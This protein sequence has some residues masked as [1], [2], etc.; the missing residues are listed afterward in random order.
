MRTFILY[1]LICIAFSC[2]CSHLKSQAYLPLL[3]VGKKWSVD[4]FSVAY[5]A[6]TSFCYTEDYF[7]SG[8]TIIDG[9]Q[10]FKVALYQA[11]NIVGFLREDV[12]ERKIYALLDAEGLDYDEEILM[13]DFSLQVGD[14]IYLPYEYTPYPLKLESIETITLLDGAI[15]KKI[16]FTNPL[17]LY[18]G[19][20][21]YIEGIGGA[22][23]LM[24]PLESFF[25]T[26]W[27]LNCVTLNDQSLYGSSSC[28]IILNTKDVIQERVVNIFP[29]PFINE[30]EIISPESISEIS[31]FDVS[32]DILKRHKIH[33]NKK[34]K[35]KINNSSV[36][37]YF[38]HLVFSDGSV[39]HKKIV[40][41]N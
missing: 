35:I 22:R 25:E 39:A 19:D 33:N 30:I 38:L 24:F 12:S 11:Q 32:G 10:Y 16:I 34:A 31:L 37:V 3:E 8:D 18:E 13:Y 15:S 23:G 1:V 21:F 7:L 14:S 9:N 5:C 41:A 27:Y 6:P 20:S 36:G 40:K 2:K 26:T 17:S 29:N 28:E 4:Y